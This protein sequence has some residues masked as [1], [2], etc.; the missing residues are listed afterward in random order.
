MGK[1]I[2]L[3]TVGSFGDLHPFL[4]VGIALKAR[5]CDVT[6]AAMGEY[7]SKV[8]M[9]GLTFH[10]LRRIPAR[11]RPIPDWTMPAFF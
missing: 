8:E 9:E 10:E 1:Q 11:S 4:A 6:V 2:V 3:T 5:C 7:K